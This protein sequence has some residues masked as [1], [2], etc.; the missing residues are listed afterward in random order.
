M[1]KHKYTARDIDIF[2]RNI[3]YRQ[4]L[5]P[6]VLGTERLQAAARRLQLRKAASLL[7]DE[8]VLDSSDSLRCFKNPLPIRNSLTQQSS[9][10]FLRLRRPFLAVYRPD[11]SR[12]RSNPCHRV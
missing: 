8:V 3:F 2:Y 11:S 10:T 6:R 1:N 9:V 12:I 4:V 5:S 7:L